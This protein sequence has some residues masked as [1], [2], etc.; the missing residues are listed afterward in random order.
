MRKILYEPDLVLGQAE[1]LTVQIRKDLSL[2]AKIK[3]QAVGVQGLVFIAPFPVLFVDAVFAVTDQRM[4]DMRKM[5]S[6]LMSFS[7]M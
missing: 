1:F 7:G 3:A 6:Y 5:R 2:A 4:T